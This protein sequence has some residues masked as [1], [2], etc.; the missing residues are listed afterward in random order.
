VAGDAAALFDPADQAAMAAVLR[1]LLGD[2]AER[3]RLRARGLQRV[4][5]FTW[6]RTARLTLDSYRRAL[7]AP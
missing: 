5:E 4:R 6:E 3:E 1:R 7:E 2:P